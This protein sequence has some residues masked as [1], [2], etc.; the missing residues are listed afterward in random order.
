M[1]A[2]LVMLSHPMLAPVEG[3]LAAAGFRTAR[4]WELADGERPAVRAIVH[5]GEIPLTP[6]FL[7]RLPNLGLI[8]CVSVGYD[9]VDVAW[10]RARGI[11]VTHA[12]GLN[13]DDVADHA[14]GLLLAS[15]RNIVLGDRIVREGGWRDDDRMRPRPGLKGRKLGVVGLGAIGEAVA[16]R[17]EAFGLEAAWWGPRPKDA[18]WPRAE[19]LL[20]LAQDSDILVVACRAD[21][22]NRGLI[23]REVIEAVGPRGLIVN[24]ARGSVVD[25]D[26]LI[27]ALKDGRLGRAALDVFAQEPTPPER[28]ADAPNTVLTPHSA[29]ST[30][31]SIPR[32]VA[33]AV[34]NVRLF[35]AGEPVMSPA[36]A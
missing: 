29:G 24:V 23:S 6:D 30:V 15:W 7:E 5:A 4:R 32:M 14:M 10:C 21:A 22:S 27:A 2:S 36:P 8:A 19:S 26:A 20:K 13:A 35:L 18:A 28:W 3:P 12:K 34:E 16:R 11:E 9:G 17:A 33:Q 31:D 25:E 1:P